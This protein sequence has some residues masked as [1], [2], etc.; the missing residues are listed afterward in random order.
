MIRGFREGDEASVDALLRAVWPDDP[1]LRDISA[2]HGADLDIDGRSRRTVVYEDGDAVIG[3]GSL[4]GSARHP[5]RLFLVVAVTPHRR[6]EGVGSALLDELRT[7][8][9][10]PMLARARESD[11]ATIAFLH[12][13]G[14]G[15]LMRSLTGVVDPTDPVVAAWVARQPAVTLTGGGSRE[16]VARAH[17]AAYRWEHESWSPATP[18]PLEE[19]LRLFCGESWIVES[20][21]LA[22]NRDTVIG[23][24]GLHGPPLASSSSELFLIA[25]TS[26]HDAAAL[27]ALVAAELVIAR[28]RS[29]RVSIEADEANAELWD[30]LGELPAALEPD[31][32]LLSTG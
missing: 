11:Q 25:G 9:D 32:L 3:A 15:M 30:V 22:R 20:A 21:L 18:R 27:R 4:V 1:V 17:E 19:S 26:S 12:A 14:F 28:T 29:A 16:E 13:H 23:V 5:T 31:L 10:R 2:I 6:R 8:A 7:T 24:A